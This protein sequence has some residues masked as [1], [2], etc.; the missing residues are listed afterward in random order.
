MMMDEAAQAA[1]AAAEMATHGHTA[2]N[3]RQSGAHNVPADQAVMGAAG[4]GGVDGGGIA[5][6]EVT[7]ESGTLVQQRFLTFLTEL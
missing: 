4:D 5:N 3:A 6:F 7:D 1:Q 2:D